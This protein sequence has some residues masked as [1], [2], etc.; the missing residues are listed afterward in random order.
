VL[1]RRPR[2][3]VLS[4]EIRDPISVDQALRHNISFYETAGKFR[5]A[6]VLRLYEEVTADFGQVIRRINDKFGTTFAAANTSCE[7]RSEYSEGD[8][9][10]LLVHRSFSL[11]PAVVQR[12]EEHTYGTTSSLAGYQ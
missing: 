5:D 1:I 11:L 2:V 10:I 4:I 9:E 3:A 6:Y 8:T 12:F 7:H